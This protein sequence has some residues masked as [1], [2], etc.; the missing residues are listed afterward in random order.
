M[1]RAEWLGAMLLAAALLCRPEVGLNAA[2]EAMAAWA[3]SVAPALFPFMALTPLLTGPEA[4]RAYERL[5]GR[6]MRPLLKLPGSAAPAIVIAMTAGSPAG[7]I[8]A[9][10]SARQA[11]LTRGQLER[12]VC[13]S[14]GLSPA[15][16]MTGIGVSMLGSPASGAVLLRSQIAAQIM[17]LIVTRGLRGSDLPA[18]PPPPSA[19]AEPVRMAVTGTLNVCGYMMLFSVI[20]AMLGQILP[21]E[22][23]R[24]ALLCL[25][26]L[27]S[28]A[29][30]LCSMPM[31]DAL[32]LILLAAASGLGG[33]CIAAQNLSACSGVRPARYAAAR[34][35]QAALMALLTLAQLKMETK[36]IKIM[37]ILPFSALIACIMAV[38][39]LIFWINNTFLNKQ[40]LPQ[41][42]PILLEN[43]EKPQHVV[44][45]MENKA[46][47]MRS[48]EF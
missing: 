36:P 38:P 45:N 19:A 4:V 31:S 47:I 18:D 29:R 30:A 25:L 32:R 40:N 16:L 22:A 7:A 43:G 3:Q 21:G 1:G 46:N 26:D 44:V 41:N 24:A 48:K 20:G 6:M 14:C 34:L 2:R 15:F 42:A 39:V 12:I 17:M 10:R 37:E 5:L 28:G 13:C 27:P 23:P 9:A 33:L 8:A 11:G 35:A